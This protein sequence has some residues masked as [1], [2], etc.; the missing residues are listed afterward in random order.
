MLM[1]ELI[2]WPRI[3]YHRTWASFRLDLHNT[4]VAHRDR[5]MPCPWKNARRS[6]DVLIPFG[7]VWRGGTAA[8]PVRRMQRV[9]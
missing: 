4:C 5:A 7:R 8:Q 9:S 6:G 2:L 1:I 3:H